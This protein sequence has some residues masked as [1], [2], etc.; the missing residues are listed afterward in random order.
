M[1]KL[2]AVLALL[3]VPAVALG[4]KTSTAGDQSLKLATGVTPAKASKQGKPRNVRLKVRLDY[5][6]LGEGVQIQENT[7]SVRFR[8]P[9]GMKLHPRRFES[10]LLSALA[11]DND[12]GCPAGS[13]VGSG[14]ATA[15]ARP[16]IADPLPAQV[17]L[18]S[19]IDDV[20]VDGTPRVPGTPAMILL[21]KTPLGVNSVLPF[22][23]HGN[24]LLLEFAPPVPGEPQ[25]FHLQIVD[26]TF[27][28]NG[29]VTAPASCAGRS[30]PFSLTIENFDGPSVTA[31]HAVRCAKR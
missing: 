29:Y 15:D 27:P 3:L 12:N 23:I 7:K 5:L 26:L 28:K 2:A 17:T 4:G 9:A 24:E 31:R 13:V 20:N 1:R 16:A 19:G 25:I 22:D 11:A 21:A 14:T 30:W 10:C 8:S 6:S 18:Y